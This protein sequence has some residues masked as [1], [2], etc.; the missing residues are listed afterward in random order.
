M[1][2]SGEDVERIARWVHIEYGKL[3]EFVGRRVTKVDPEIIAA[4]MLGQ[5]IEYHS[6][7]LSG[8]LLGASCP[9]KSDLPVYDEGNQPIYVTLDEQ[10]IFID[11][12]LHSDS[13]NAGRYHFTVAHEV[14][15][16]LLWE[17]YP[18]SRGDG[19]AAR[20]IR[21]CEAPD[22][23]TTD[24]E[25]DADALAAAILMPPLLIRRKME[26][27]GLKEK[28]PM[29]NRIYARDD[30][31]RFCEIADSLGVSKTALCIRMKQLGLIEREYL[32]APHDLVN[33]YVSD[34]FEG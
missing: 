26:E 27:H 5:R 13:A 11:S 16:K 9:G 3:P 17:I 34:D 18:D 2:L 8:K 33:I 12:Y 24:E 21:Y 20:R 10:T 6:L 32:K 1:R 30:Y 29:L 23:N 4:R 28:I 22:R 31:N 15:H 25:R 19:P 7:S 14:S